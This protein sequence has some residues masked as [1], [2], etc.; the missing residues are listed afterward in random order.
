MSKDKKPAQVFHFDLY[1]KRED[2]YK[3][4]NENSLSSIKFTELNPQMPEL[5]F[6]PKDFG[7]KAE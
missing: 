4:L 7:V 1:G 3:F 6:V 5:F 2:K